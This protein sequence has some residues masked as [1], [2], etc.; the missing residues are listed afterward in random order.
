MVKQAIIKTPVKDEYLEFFQNC[1]VKYMYMP[2]VYNMEE[3]RKVLTYDNINIV[4][5][6][7]IAKTADSEMIDP[8]NL[9]WIR[10]A[11]AVHLGQQHQ[12][13]QRSRTERHLQ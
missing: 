6:E 12:S 7:A 4:G 11:G 9:K 8:E 13:G 1:P 2:I 3:L 5:V 10:E